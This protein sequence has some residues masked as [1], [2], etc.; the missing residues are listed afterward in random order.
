MKIDQKT[1]LALYKKEVDNIF[2]VCD[3]KTHLT[4]EE[5]I[6]IL[7]KLLEN[8]PSLIDRS[9]EC[10]V[11]GTHLEEGERCYCWNDE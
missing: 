1:L 7:S 6:A 10:P 8:T 4:P 5:I 3:W 11:C 2:N 9:D